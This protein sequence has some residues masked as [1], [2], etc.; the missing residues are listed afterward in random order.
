MKEVSASW[1]SLGQWSPA[2][3]FA[4]GG[5]MLIQVLLIGLRKY[6][7]AS[8]SELLIAP[9]AIAA[10]VAGI[11]GLIGLHPRIAGRAPRLACAGAGS[12]LA[13]GMILCVLAAWLIGS[14]LMGGIPQPPPGWFL[15]AIATFMLAFIMAFILSSA[16]S[17][18][19][20]GSIRTVG[21]L[22]L[23]PVISWGMILV[24]GIVTSMS[25][26]LLLD[27]YTNGLISLAFLAIGYILKPQRERYSQ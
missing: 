24:V 26:A 20:D 21:Y 5:L 17:L 13:A 15:A 27:F 18:R 3:F 12:A 11:I 8:F 23:V 16:A 4:A 25:E 6:N 2:L 14:G 9:P 10:L 7:V 19:D 1:R 22:L